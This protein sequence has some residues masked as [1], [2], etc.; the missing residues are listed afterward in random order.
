MLLWAHI[1]RRGRY[2]RLWNLC[3]TASLQSAYMTMGHSRYLKENTQYTIKRGN[4]LTRTGVIQREYITLS[5]YPRQGRT[6]WRLHPKLLTTWPIPPLGVAMV[7]TVA[8]PALTYNFPVGP[9]VLLGTPLCFI[10]KRRGKAG[11]YH[12][13]FTLLHCSLHEH[14]NGDIVPGNFGYLPGPEYSYNR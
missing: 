8:R 14:C 3:P 12:G 1:T 2:S 7:Y 10:A 5:L 9:R 4:D 13:L 11:A 6:P